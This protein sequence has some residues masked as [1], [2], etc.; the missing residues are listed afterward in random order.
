MPTACFD[1]T[2]TPTIEITVADLSAVEI[3][4]GSEMSV[5]GLANETFAVEMAGRG[6]VTLAGTTDT[7]TIEMAG[8]GDVYASDL[9]A[10]AV[11]IAMLGHGYAEIHATET[12]DVRIFGAGQVVNTGDGEVTQEITGD[13]DVESGV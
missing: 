13:G 4:G 3:A 11:E 9:I 10:R 7:L 1:A 8:A 2:E 12:L 6:A 5:A